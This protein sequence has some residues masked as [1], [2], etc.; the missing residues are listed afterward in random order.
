MKYF[1]SPRQDIGLEFQQDWLELSITEHWK[2]P[3]NQVRNL[4]SELLSAW[5]I[6]IENEIIECAL[7]SS[8]KF[9]VID[10]PSL[11]ACASFSVWFRSIVDHQIELIVYD[12]SYTVDVE[13]QC[14]T[15]N[16]DI[17]NAFS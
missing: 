3:E 17:I 8:K 7:G 10:S 13:L 4:S 15:S 2:N 14:T 16:E 5:E 12:D 9:I 11:R 1:I 6:K